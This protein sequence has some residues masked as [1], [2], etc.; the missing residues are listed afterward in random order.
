MTATVLGIAEGR[1]LGGSLRVVVT[2]PRALTAARAA[3]EEV[4]AAIDVAAS[5]FREDSELSR[6]NASP[7]RVVKVGPL[8]ARAIEAA[9]RGA[10]LT[11]GAVDPT[12]GFAV[13]IAGYDRDFDSVPARGGPLRLVASRV[14]GW[15]A[16]RFSAATRTVVIPRGVELDLGATAKALASDMAAAAAARVID[17]GGVLVS[18][19]GDIAV[20]GEAPVGGWTIQ[21]SEDSGAELA[22]AEETV[23]IASGGLATSGTTVRRWMRGEV[24]LHHIIDP[25]TG[26]PVDS[27][28]RTATVAAGSCVDANIAS[29]AAIVMG[30]RAPRWLRERG[31][32]ARLVDRDGVVHRLAG[33]PKAAESKLIPTIL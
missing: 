21:A 29:T 10:E 5:R 11:E 20:A 14:P 8:L 1:A 2:R 12:I 31:M 15:S 24:T 17:G 7:D 13:R 22:D 9:L 25:A 23:S 33:W 26:L 16:V 27:V 30:E 18:L 19:G 3:V 32:A 28:W 6:L 4:V